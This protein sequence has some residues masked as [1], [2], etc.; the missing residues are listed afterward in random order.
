GVGEPG[1]D[2]AFAVNAFTPDFLQEAVHAFDA[3]GVPGLHG[4]ER[5]EEHQVEAQR[6]RAVTTDDVVGVGDVATGLGH[7]FAVFA[8]NDA[9]VKE[10]GE[11][12]GR[13]HDAEVEENFVP[14]ARVEQVEHGVLGAADV[15]VGPLPVIEQLGRG[16]GC[17]VLGVEVAQVIPA[18][19]GPLRHGVGLAAGAHVVGRG[20]RLRGGNGGT[21][22]GVIPDVHPV[23]DGGEGAFA[24]AGGLVAGDLGQGERQGG[25]GHGQ[26]ATG[27]AVDHAGDGFGRQQQGGAGGLGV[28]DGGGVIG[29]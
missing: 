17:V 6:I 11:G 8:E 28:G 12:L 24:G 18:G 5:A 19:A 20:L 26:R 25:F 7:F 16:D 29:L 23:G 9:L 15:D 2:A 14:E 10:L 1:V 27:L 22:G 13:G 4:L 21:G 3:V